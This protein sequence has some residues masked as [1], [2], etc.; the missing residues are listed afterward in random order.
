MA[1]TAIIIGAVVAF[2]GVVILGIAVYCC[3]IAPRRRRQLNKK[4]NVP[5]PFQR[6]TTSQKQQQQQQA[7]RMQVVTSTANERLNSISLANHVPRTSSGTAQSA[8]LLKLD[9]KPTDSNTDP[10]RGRSSSQSTMRSTAEQLYEHLDDVSRSGSVK[11]VPVD[12]SS[13]PRG[14]SLFV[15]VNVASGAI[16]AEIDAQSAAQSLLPIYTREYESLAMG[17]SSDTDAVYGNAETII[18]KLTVSPDEIVLGKVIGTGAFGDVLVAEW[19]ARGQQGV[20]VA[21]KRL[22]VDASHD[23]AEAQQE[24]VKEVSTM[25]QLSHVNIVRVL[26]LTNEPPPLIVLEFISGGSLYDWMRAQTHP[27]PLNV[28]LLMGQQA[29]EGLSYL[30]DHGVVH[31]DVAA[32]NVLVQWHSASQFVC[33]LSDFGLSRVFDKLAYRSKQTTPIPVRWTALEVRVCDV[34]LSEANHVSGPVLLHLLGEERRVGVRR[35][36]GWCFVWSRLISLI[37]MTVGNLH[38]LPHLPIREPL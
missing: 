6:P 16:F 22:K 21:V 12:R 13:L 3:W 1:G 27:A 11:Y 31:R 19:R 24:F 9:G 38:L 2:V 32:R 17:S 34:M 15:Q 29:A 4:T 18:R 37:S 20:K 7:P 8:I 28:Q 26:A 35:A 33:K 5:A 14:Q 36:A 30:A 10:A 25:A 23:D